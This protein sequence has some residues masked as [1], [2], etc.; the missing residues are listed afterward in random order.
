MSEMRL[1]KWCLGGATAILVALALVVGAWALIVVGY[2][3]AVG[4]MG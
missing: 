3:Y 4:K 1:A 2:M